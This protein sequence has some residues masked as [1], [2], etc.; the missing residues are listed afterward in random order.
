MDPL[1]THSR[2]GQVSCPRV[3]GESTAALMWGSCPG[4]YGELLADLRPRNTHIASFYSSSTLHEL[5]FIHSLFHSF[6]NPQ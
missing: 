3:T 4:S 5:S 1:S 6:N 2:A